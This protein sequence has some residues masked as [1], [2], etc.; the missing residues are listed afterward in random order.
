MNWFVAI[1]QATRKYYSPL[2]KKWMRE[3]IS[4]AIEAEVRAE[5]ERLDRINAELRKL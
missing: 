1:S 3:V 5:Q 4:L 2:G